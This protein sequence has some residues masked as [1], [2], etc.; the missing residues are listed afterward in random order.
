MGVGFIMLVHQDLDRAA[1]VAG[2]WAQ[3]DCPV[4]IH[5]DT[6]TNALEYAQFQRSLAQF[7][8]V[9]FANRHACDW[10]KFSIVHATQD[11]AEL[12]LRDFADV[13][14]VFLASG[15]CLPLRPVAELTQYL[16]ER[17][18]TDFIE[19]VTTDEVVWT[20]GGLDRER[21]TLRFP[22]SWKRRRWFFDR[23]VEM[24]RAL[25]F[26]RRVPRGIEPHLGSQWWCL[27]RATL[28]AILTD[29]DR[30]QYDRYFRKVWIPDEAYFQTLVRRFSSNIESRSLTLARFDYQGKPHI[31]YDDHI[32]LLQ[33]SDC[34][35]ARKI[36]PRANK[37]YRRFLADEFKPLA[38]VES[39][40]RKL[41]RIFAKAI[42]QRTRGRS[43]LKM[44]SRFPRGEAWQL[45]KTCAPYSV[46]QGFSDL[47]INF[48]TWLEKRTGTRI[49]GHLFDK[50]A[51]R[52]SGN[53]EVY[54]GCLSNS[55]KLRDYNAEAFMTNL[56]WSTQ[57]EHQSFQFGPAD[58]QKITAFMASDQNAS[59]HVISGAWAVPL[60]NS[61]FDF[62]RIRRIAA[63]Y[64][65]IE[66][67]FISTLKLRDTRA[68]FKIW[69]LAEFVEN[70]MPILQSIIDSLDPG[71][72]R[73]LTEVPKMADLSGF[74][75][76]VQRLKNEGMNP[77]SVGDFPIGDLPIY[78]K[79][80]IK[81]YVVR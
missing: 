22:F 81:P 4:V 61:N 24:Q 78:K 23:Y 17:A 62:D 13:S 43:G 79:I 33:R 68:R 59:I 45:Q 66:L 1:Q 29:R 28:T 63:R 7:S 2:Y 77:H 21:F 48:E 40:P 38:Q 69:T 26:T 39:N 73:R 35:V 25:G 47:F 8:N 37:L 10:G 32:Q 49:H 76:F 54:N 53:A 16:A 51:V 55:A 18:D 65:T 20:V 41:D 44:Q 9:R 19:S 30:R 50:I 15:S 31:F 34:F 72:Y 60:F 3:N 52:F 56:I 80:P 12:L 64:Q 70:P 46:Y 14:H 67:A 74:G 36:W 27:T 42:E 58:V 75:Q 6:R 5:A 11:A 57:G 71:S